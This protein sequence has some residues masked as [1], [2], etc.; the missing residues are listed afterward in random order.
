MF[1]PIQQAAAA[2]TQAE[3]SFGH[4]PR[5]LQVDFSGSLQ[6]R[7]TFQGREEQLI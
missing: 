6:K 2:G 3:G 4:T 7:D 5:V 1:V